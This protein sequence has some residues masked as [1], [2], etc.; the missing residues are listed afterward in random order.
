[1]PTLSA[2]QSNERI[3]VDKARSNVL[4]PRKHLNQRP[5]HLWASKVT[6][7]G[8]RSG[9]ELGAPNDGGSWASE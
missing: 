2:F 1:M 9:P 7:E 4:D 6:A 3:L 8:D 5:A